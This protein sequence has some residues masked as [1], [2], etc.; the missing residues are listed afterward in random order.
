M[1]PF[2]KLYAEIDLASLHYVTFLKPLAVI[3]T[4]SVSF[5]LDQFMNNPIDKLIEEKTSDISFSSE[6]ICSP[7]LCC[8][9]KLLKFNLRTFRMKSLSSSQNRK[10]SVIRFVYKKV[11]HIKYILI[12]FVLQKYTLKVT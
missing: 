11:D 4:E 12:I 9:T 8:V 1:G 3:S 5:D 2:C 10:A 7:Q 6:N